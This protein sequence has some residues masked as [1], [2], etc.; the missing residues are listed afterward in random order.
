MLPSPT[1]RHFFSNIE[2]VVVVGVGGCAMSF[3]RQTKLRL[4][5]VELRLSWGYDN[6][7]DI[8]FAVVV[9]V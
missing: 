6:I 3:S 9:V 8:E 1:V 4:C 7:S 5:L 2:F